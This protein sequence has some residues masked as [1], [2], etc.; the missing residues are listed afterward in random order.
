M[1]YVYFMKGQ[2]GNIKIGVSK[3][4]DARLKELQT[5]HSCNLKI[6]ERFPFESRLKA[7][8]IEKQLHIR[9]RKFKLRGEWFKYETYSEFKARRAKDF[10]YFP[11]ITG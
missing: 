10:N 7:Y 4:P 5:G 8:D 1:H 6:L 3:D 2:L 11:F 9:F